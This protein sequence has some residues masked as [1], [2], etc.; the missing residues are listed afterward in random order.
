MSKESSADIELLK[1]ELLRRRLNK[2]A[3]P[4]AQ[5]DGARPIARA[6]RDGELPLSWAQQ[7]MWFLDRLDQAAGEAYHVPAAL[8]LKGRLDRLALQSALDRIVARHENLR[9]RFIGVDGSARQQIA[10]EQIGFV[11]VDHDL[12]A[13]APAEREAEATRL[14]RDEALAA[15]DLAAGP[16]IRGRLLRVGDDEHILLVTQHH[17]ISDGWSMGVL[18]REV[19]ALYTAFTQGRADPLPALP[20]QY[21]D[22]AVW[23]RQWLQGEALQKHIDFWRTHLGGAPTLLELPGD[24]PRPPLQS[25]AGDRIPVALPAALTTAL[26]AL[27]QRHGT[28]VFMTLLAGWSALM[29]RLSGQDE[30]VIGTPVANRA[31]TE[32]EPL[33]GLFINT[34]ALRVDL[35]DDPTVAELLAQVKT[36]TLGAYAHQELPFEQVV[37][38]LAPERSLGHSPLFQVMLTLDNTP[39]SGSLALPGLELSAVP[40]TNAKAH[41]DLRLLLGDAG[42]DLSGELEYSSDLFDRATAERMVRQWIALL[43]GMVGGDARKVGELALLTSAER[44]LVLRE[45]NDLRS[46][47]VHDRTIHALFEEQAAAA[48]DAEALLVEDEVLSY[49][50]LN[51][52]AN[53]V[54]HRLI[55]LGVK[56]DDRVAICTERSVAMIVGLLGVLKAGAGYVPLDPSYPSE[57]LAYMLEDS[58][59]IALL[60]QSALRA[61]MPML[62]SSSLPVV[63]LDDES[64]SD[65]S[66]SNPRIDGLTPRH[67]AYVIYTSGSTG[68]PKGVMV[69]HRSAVNFWR[70]MGE[71]THRE[72][73]AGSR[74]A[75]NAAF[76]FDMSLK[77]ILQ[78][79]SGHALVLIPQSI[80]AN[81]P[82]ML[83]F[84]DRYRIDAFDSTPS[85]LEVLL[86]AGLIGKPGHQPTSVLLGGEPIGK[87]MWDKL[88]A[89]PS[90]HFHNMYGPTECTVDATIGSIR[91]AVGGPNIGR[92]I[93]NTPVYL[94]DA[95]GEPV[96]VGVP[97]E[98]FLG[99]VQVA[100]GYLDR[101]E[102]TAE[103][104]LRDPFA[105]DADA[106]M[107]KTGD[108]G[109]WR[110]DGT[111]E[112]L[113]RNDFQVKIRGFRIEL[114]EIEARLT[115]CDGVREAVVIAREED[116][117]DKRLVAYVVAEQGAEISVTNLREALARDLAE[118]MI[119]SAF[120]ALD[121][122]PL[123]PNGKLDRKA[124][125]SPDQ[126]ALAS[127]EYE[128]PLGETEQAIAGVW[129]DL[130]GIERVGRH[131]HFFELGG[132]S[133]L[134]ISLIER[135]RQCG[136]NVDVRT[137][138]TT[139]VLSVLA[140]K[141]AGEA[142][143]PA[144]EVAPN[145]IVAG[146]TAITPELLPLVSL[147]QAEIDAIVATVPG[148]AGNVQDIYPLAPLQ[149]GI[150]FHH[151]LENDSGGDTYLL[152]TVLGFDGRERM[153]AFLAALQQVI[154]RHDILRSAVI[155]QGLPQPV[156][157]VYRQAPL[158]LH[159]AELSADSPALPQL[160]AH[161]DP[162]RM[163]LDLQRAP[164]LAAFRAQD[165]DSGEWLLALLRHHVSGDHVAMALILSEIL[166]LL[167]GRGE[168]LQ[169]SLPYRNFIA[170]T[171]AVPEA[172][173]EAWFREQLGHVD[174]P[175]APFG[176]L[177]VQSSGE[178][179]REARIVFDDALARR[180]RE[181]ARERGVTP[182]VLFHV[183]WAQV[184]ARCS[185][186]DE[187]VFGTV[188]S[189]RLQGSEGA[190]QVVGMF[191]NTLPIRIPV[192]G[193][194]VAE[195]VRDTHRRLSELLA[196]EQASLALAQRCSAIAPPLPLFTAL[197]NYRHSH[198]P[199]NAAEE[200]AM[201]EAWDGVYVLK[202][203]TRNNYPLT[204]SVEDLGQ[205]FGLT[206][207]SVPGID[208]PRVVRYMQTAMESLIAALESGGETPLQALPILP[209]SEREQVLSGFNDLRSDAVHDR[210][211]HGLFEAQAAAVPDSDALLVEDEVLSYAELNRRA[212]RVAHRLIALGVKPD[213]RVAIC[214]ERSVAMIV[215]LLGVL[216]A[217]AGYVPLDPSYPI[218]RLAYML[219]DSRPIALL[220]QSALRAAM[221]ML[222]SSTL[223]VVVLDDES[224][225]SYSESNPS[226]EG[227]TPRHLAYVIYT[228]GSTGQ[229]KGVMVEHRSAVNFWRVMGETTHRELSGG[230]RV[231]LNAAF[232]FDMSLKGILQLLSGHALVLIPQAIRANGPAMLDFIDRYRI[233]A[234]DSTPS[235]LEVLLAAGLIGKPGHQPT[236]V[237]LGGEPIG[238]A[239]WDKLQA[240][241]SIHFHNMYGPTECTV[242]ATIGSIRDAVGGPNIGRPIANTPV[243]LLDARG[244]PVPVGVPGELFL[245]GVQVARG[246]LD[247][248]ELTAERFLRD[249]FAANEDAR[250]Y[251][252]GDLGRWRADGTIEYLGRNDFQVKIRGFRIELGEIEARLTAC[253]GV[254][255]AVVIAREEDGGDKRLVAYVV[256]EQGAEISVTNLREALA[257]ELAE[258]MIPS[259]FVALDALPLN[260]NGKLDRKALP[261][262]DQSA[263]ASREYEAPLGEV[264]QTLAAIWQDLLGI[265]RV[266]RHDHFFELGGHS[267]LIM[268][269]AIRVRER[270]EVEIP[271][272]TLFEQPTLSFLAGL[273]VSAQIESFAESDVADIEQSLGELSESELLALLS[274][275]AVDER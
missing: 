95:R 203:D 172:E 132:H 186:R 184:L 29:S 27:S 248:P 137:V 58:R 67:L 167:Q 89:S 188:L 43:Q 157:V 12:R 66:E 97:G 37:E 174:E 131:D 212:N 265:E 19:S 44:E 147:S 193:E 118:Y 30:V 108:L 149:E 87:A 80:R 263:L 72:L 226:V 206:A 59:P 250:M 233:D 238:K 127:R 110:A 152:R 104:F 266:G 7:R 242:D 92:P 45:F 228:S 218:E 133:L 176:V 138:F 216:K 213:D 257:R 253:D 123:T 241:P 55:A 73:S 230:S 11:L 35:R 201:A 71:T 165:P 239:M 10:P 208:G 207:L 252:T 76:S 93:A 42:E 196:H 90:I 112:Y 61:A 49:A 109:R 94:L 177:D 139:P 62:E 50:E 166:A 255:E 28:T 221:P 88:Q 1:L 249:P 25:Y 260:P 259:A 39:D 5:P 136:L 261:S 175:T 96:P 116:G 202:D 81:G 215:G 163:R 211:I 194:A 41:F 22:Y 21:A 115:A 258:Y 54:A 256:A 270:F 254:R 246:Y 9:T 18:V 210:T 158:P 84:I 169:A 4:A 236:S 154:D 274:E 190:D 156:Q 122:L 23:Q 99:G 178:Q 100:R 229:P 159:E 69:E 171:R 70:V 219:E 107:Y 60:T 198:E 16:L 170:A 36:T 234:F 24:R 185:G 161:T 146:T 220:T 128:A 129:Q 251:K 217:G 247:R 68:Q 105:Q 34:L 245:G 143:A 117:G 140:G 82:A 240:S 121:A 209:V 91:D 244:E 148:G 269:L 180:I 8:R 113:G 187:V 192:G 14:G 2:S 264:E 231:A 106:R 65:Q 85:Q 182:A 144:A 57:R 222:E 162:R 199:G 135:L 243:Y 63:V 101:P 271:L 142:E 102:L 155:W 232:S 275:D 145:L 120:M 98:L 160:L 111:I 130:L 134:V 273:V 214:T 114:G 46:D 200:Q 197:L 53:R 151:M 227:L 13:L 125:P 3:T 235:Q 150:L 64:L 40:A 6:D 181:L 48:P 78:L 15:F 119:P 20:V 225:A 262:P 75:L 267:L 124:L 237:L 56:P 47:A 173:H 126:S 268:Q 17:I 79:L 26:R 83:D 52:R 86:A 51:R 183:A 191:L 195:A 179:A 74:V 141:I 33:I 189:G 272:R 223:P 164:I 168:A 38:A 31:R 224:L 204:M 103:R 32:L 205:G 153:D 77:G